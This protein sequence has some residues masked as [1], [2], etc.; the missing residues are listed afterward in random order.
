M[1]PVSVALGTEAT[2]VERT[3]D[4]N[5]SHMLEAPRAAEAHRGCSFVEILQNCV[6]FD[7]KTWDGITHRTERD[8][9]L[10]FLEDGKPL[11]F[12]ADHNMGIT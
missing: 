1:S 3:M 11:L 6:I 2:F 5:P 7:D 8:D 12:G 4:S 9:N 10:L